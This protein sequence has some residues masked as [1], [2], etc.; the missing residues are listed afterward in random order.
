ML[1]INT[2]I[3]SFDGL[4][5]TNVIIV[6]ECELKHPIDYIVQ[7]LKSMQCVEIVK[8]LIYTVFRFNLDSKINALLINSVVDC[9][10]G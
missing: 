1:L 10:F 6:I 8:I 3:D 5:P 2:S 4:D 9:V 7:S